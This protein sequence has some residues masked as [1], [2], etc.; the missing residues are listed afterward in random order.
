[1]FTAQ[2][3]LGLG[4]AWRGA[5]KGGVTH[6]QVQPEGSR[7]VEL[8]RYV[9]LKL[10]ALGE[11][12]SD[13]SADS[14]FVDVTRPLLRNHFEK[15][16][17]LGWP[18]C[19]VDRRIQS[20]LDGY[21]AEVCPNGAP[22]LPRK[23]LVLDRPGL[24]RVLSLPVQGQQLASPFLT[25][26]RVE[27]GVLHNPKSDRRT[28]K[29]V[30]HVAEGGLPVPVDK[31]AV[32]KRTF[33]L[34]LEAALQPSA[35][36]MALPYTAGD[37]EQA[38]VFVSLL[39]RPIVC[40]ATAHEPHKTMEIRFFA[41]GSLVS[42]LDF[43]ESIFGNAGD[44]FLPENDAGLDPRA[45][46]GHTG[47]VILAPHLVGMKKVELGLPH[48]D[49]ASERQRRDG[50]CY[51]D[52]S[53]PYNDGNAF[54]ITCRD[55]RGVIVTIIADN[56][57]GYCK[58]EVKTQISYAANLF[59][60]CEEEHAGGVLA[61]P[62]YVLGL[63]FQATAGLELQPT[64]FAQALELL[65]PRARPMPEGHA[66]DT[67]YDDIFYVPDDAVFSVADGTVRFGQGER[68]H[69]LKLTPE[70]V[71]V[72]P[73]G[74]R[75]RLEKHPHGPYFR[76]VGTRAEGVLCH[77]PCTVSGGGKS[78]I[79]KPLTPMIQPA[80]VFV[81]DFE[82]DF[83]RVAE[84]LKQDFSGCF[85][86]PP[87][88]GR[89]TRSLLGA[90]RSL[91]SV[92]KLLTPSSDYTDEHNAWLRALPQTIRELVFIVK[93]LYRPEWGDDIQSHFSVDS[94]N[95]YAG[96]ELRF[97]KQ[98]LLTNQLRVG[99]EPGGNAWRMFKLRPDFHPCEK[100]QM[101]DDITA[102]VIVPRSQV[103]GVSPGFAHESLK[104][105]T[106]CEEYLFQRPDDAVHRGF[107]G[108]AEA[109]LS[110]P[111]TFITN[112]EPLSGDDAQ[113]LVDRVA[114]LEAFTPPMRQLLTGFARAPH[115]GYVVSSAHPRMVDG[116]PSKNPRYLQRRPDRVQHREAYLGEVVTRLNGRIA[117]D[118]PRLD[119][120]HAVLAGRRANRAQP[121]IGLPPLAV[122]G[123]LHYQELPELF[124]DFLS[125]LTG[126]SP[127]TTGFGS[128]GALTKGPFNAL[129]PVVDV[130]NALVSAILTGYGGFTSVAGQLGPRYR[131]DHDVS[132]LVPE[133]WCRM[134]EREREPG[135][136]IEHGY[137]EKVQDFE[138][139]GRRVL[140]G[141][142]GYRITPRFVEHF[143]GRLFQTPNAVFSEDMLR[144]ELQG[145]APYAAGID[146]IVE[147]QTRVARSYFEDGSVEA[148]C[149]PLL[150][151]L[152]VMAH[153]HY[154]GVGIEQPELR[155]MF[156]R[157][158]LV[159]SEWYRERL[160]TKQHR[161]LEL[162]QRH[163]VTLDARLRVLEAPAD[164][165]VA[166]RL[167]VSR[168]L[169]HVGRPA[170]LDEL[171][172]TLG[173]DPFHLQ[174]PAR[175]RSS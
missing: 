44:P 138:L 49:Q 168:R 105:V 96:H 171:V 50:M 103:P 52:E 99:F 83:A 56:Y 148:A 100:V 134:S 175:T 153:G 45:W 48:Y 136:L 144:P 150:A 29:G 163:A 142:L 46:T 34:L 117:V 131:V 53:E 161:E 63:T 122:F 160:A 15:D 11:P 106:N 94:V 157:E 22:R 121:E 77:K 36:V 33:A 35:E 27:Q 97:D 165:L 60:S 115:A 123:P 91:G 118:E 14:E 156:T 75:V 146:A 166:R 164:E 104:V 74:Y 133:L 57:Y 42:N 139:E 109:D 65:G 173:A 135:Y 111:G 12:V 78:E 26:Y 4:R 39:L 90:E 125:S 24:G 159:K 87:A 137:L 51:R 54:K 86:R 30:F 61:F 69:A 82:H 155:A 73:S 71:F 18:L 154:R 7:G 43:V 21:L 158:A 1:M 23:T 3:S 124:M 5:C 6:M 25:S 101:E 37:A 76:L 64:S 152:H 16:A 32:P 119:V 174:V 120:V 149:P 127:S 110:T 68:A 9:K 84:I 41:P 108:Q 143:L 170:Y 47:C 126:K 172:G 88:D 85:K 98:R 38:R 147:T 2:G 141:R 31:Q 129:W 19:S 70:R 145:I 67:R 114:E 81:K 102:S 93:R 10:L 28:T 80:P 130:N 151:L 107:D 89:A 62:S 92:V 59:G 79:S 8:A 167:F 13:S 17:L 162:F 140:A 58:K 40:P 95:G 132:M 66:V 116:K 72:L 113:K 55:E 169:E 20:Y 128:E 112:F